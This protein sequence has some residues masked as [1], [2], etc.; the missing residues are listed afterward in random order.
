MAGVILTSLPLGSFSMKVSSRVF[1]TSS[2][3]RFI[4]RSRSHTSQSVAPGARCNT[5]VGRFGID[6]ELK[7][8]CALGA[9][10]PLVVWAA[11]IALD[12]DDLAID[13]MDQGA[14]AHR[15]IGADARRHLGIF[16]SEL[17]GSRDSGSE[18]DAGADQASEGRA[19]GC[20]NRQSEKIT[21]GNFHGRTSNSRV[22]NPADN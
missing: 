9:E 16:D 11:R 15:A 13:G 7:D 6:V 10:R 19:T 21:S 2:A 20:A 8:R 12:V 14:A 4:A 18:I 5:W 1:F 3:I 22:G 17:L